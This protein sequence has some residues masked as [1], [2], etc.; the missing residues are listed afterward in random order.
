MADFAA[1]RH[2]IRRWAARGDAARADREEERTLPAATDLEG[3]RRLV[4]TEAQ[5][6]QLATVLGMH[7]RQIVGLLEVHRRWLMDDELPLT[8]GQGR[9]IYALLAG[10]ERC[11]QDMPLFLA[12]LTNVW[13]IRSDGALE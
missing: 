5:G 2:R 9:W 8:R 12:H 4:N 1:T 13:R 3:W 10:L 7:Q 11:A 6:P